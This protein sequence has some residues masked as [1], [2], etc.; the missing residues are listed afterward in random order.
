MIKDNTGSLDYYMFHAFQLP[1]SKITAISNQ[2]FL[3]LGIWDIGYIS[4]AQNN[5]N[6]NNI[7][8]IWTHKKKG[9]LE[10]Y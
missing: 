10:P 5:N 9:F 1:S 6:D 2:I 7:F 8:I 3:S 4:K